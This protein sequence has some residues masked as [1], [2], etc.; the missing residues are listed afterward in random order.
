MVMPVTFGSEECGQEGMYMYLP[1]QEFVLKYGETLWG[2]HGLY[3]H[4]PF[5]YQILLFSS[6]LVKSG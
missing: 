4:F 3:I 5:W 6:L 1:L 2:T